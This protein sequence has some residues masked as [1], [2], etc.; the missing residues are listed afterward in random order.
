MTYSVSVLGSLGARTIVYWFEPVQVL[1][2][3]RVSPRAVRTGLGSF[4]GPAS[5]RSVFHAGNM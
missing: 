1:D 3:D 5:V 2:I 4:F